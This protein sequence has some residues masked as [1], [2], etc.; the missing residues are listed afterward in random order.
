MKNIIITGFM[1]TGKSSVGRHLSRELKMK[2]VDT[3]DLIE[4]EAGVRIAQ[5]FPQ[6]GEE[7]FRKLEAKIIND[8]ASRADMVIS[9]GGGAIINPINLEALKKNGIIIC[10]TASVDTIIS[11]IG[12]GDERPLL[13]GD[14]KREKISNLLKAREPFYKKADFIIDTTAKNIREVVREILG[15]VSSMQ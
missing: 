10:L 15:K 6:Y 9:T 7:Y 2:F 4:K 14:N 11:R 1:G 13:S 3:D 5:I 8:V 12:N